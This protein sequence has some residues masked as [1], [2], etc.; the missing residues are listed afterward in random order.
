MEPF[1]RFL[2]PEIPTDEAYDIVHEAI[3]ALPNKNELEEDIKRRAK[4]PK[5]ETCLGH[6]ERVQFTNCVHYACVVCVS[7]FDTCPQCRRP[8]DAVQVSLVFIN[9]PI[10]TSS[11]THLLFLIDR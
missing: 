8:I 4:L 9:F 10:R 2:L 6:E 11:R 3:E 7:K 1:T 5:C